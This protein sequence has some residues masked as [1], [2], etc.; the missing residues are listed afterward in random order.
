MCVFVKE[1]LKIVGVGDKRGEVVDTSHIPIFDMGHVSSNPSPP[2]QG[3]WV[4]ISIGTGSLRSYFVR[5][6]SRA[7]NPAFKIYGF[8]KEIHPWK[9]S[10][11]Q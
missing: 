6:V 11:Q 1:C 5:E 10:K 4:K 3:V 2:F 7:G 9:K 8:K